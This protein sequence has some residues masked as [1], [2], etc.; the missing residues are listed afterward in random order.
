MII[1][2]RECGEAN[3]YYEMELRTVTTCYEF[4]L[5]HKHNEDC[6]EV[7]DTVCEVEDLTTYTILDRT[8]NI[9]HQHTNTGLVENVADQ[10]SALILANKAGGQDVLCNV[11]AHYIYRHSTRMSTPWVYR[12]YP[13]TRTERIRPTTIERGLLPQD[14]A[15]LHE[16][17]YD[18][19]SLGIVITAASSTRG[20]LAFVQGLHLR[21]II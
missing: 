17:E 11:G 10:F 5:Y 4:D 20:G 15:V 3:A 8:C 12:T 14:R 6:L 19:I 13:V 1:E 9:R 16:K 2:V 18:Q 7:V 21:P